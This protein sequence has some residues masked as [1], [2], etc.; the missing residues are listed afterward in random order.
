MV[1]LES[2]ANFNSARKFIGARGSIKVVLNCRR[3]S[4]FCGHD[5]FLRGAASANVNVS[6]LERRLFSST[7]QCLGLVSLIDYIL[8]GNNDNNVIVFGLHCCFSGPS[9][10]N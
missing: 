7:D 4:L 1:A 8:G 5:A 9:T 3:V 6:M 10:M 2:N